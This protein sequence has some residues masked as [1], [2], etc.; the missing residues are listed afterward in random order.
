M[1]GSVFFFFKV[2]AKLGYLVCGLGNFKFL[3][4]KSWGFYC[5][6]AEGLCSI[7]ILTISGREE[8]YKTCWLRAMLNESMD[9]EN[10]ITST[11]MRNVI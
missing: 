9:H 5:K 2:W 3:L 8:V 11:T 6:F 7:L 1:S 4:Q 10:G